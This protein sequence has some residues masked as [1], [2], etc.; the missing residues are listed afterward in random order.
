ML[1][2]SQVTAINLVYTGSVSVELDSLENAYVKAYGEPTIALG[3]QIPYET[4]SNGS[5]VLPFDTSLNIGVAASGGFATPLPGL[6]AGAYDLVGRGGMPSLAGSV[7]GFFYGRSAVSTDF[8]MVS[9]R[10]VAIAGDTATPPAPT[11]GMVQALAMFESLTTGGPVIFFGLVQLPDGALELA[12]C[13]RAIADDELVRVAGITL[14]SYDGLLLRII[15]TGTSLAFAYSQD[16]GVTWTTL[17]A[18]VSASAATY[19]VGWFLNNGSMTLSDSIN[20][21]LVDSTVLQKGLLGYFSYLNA[22]TALFRSQ[23]PH[24]FSLDGKVDPE[25]ENKVKGWVAEIRARL[26][27]AKTALM[28]QENPVNAASAGTTT[29]QV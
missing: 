6:G 19:A 14:S 23:A 11:A 5:D 3:G 18:A 13:R 20:R 24:Q 12:V 26:I 7:S 27:A 28:A 1:L 21:M 29:E 25:A 4:L 9:R 2:T 10:I 15:R 17:Q 22:G 16:A 8:T